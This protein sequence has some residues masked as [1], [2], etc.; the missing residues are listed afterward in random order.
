MILELIMK[1]KALDNNVNIIDRAKSKIE[2]DQHVVHEQLLK[3]GCS[4]MDAVKITKLAMELTRTRYDNLPETIHEIYQNLNICMAH[5][6]GQGQQDT[7]QSARD[8]E[9]E[10]ENLEDEDVFFSAVKDFETDYDSPD[11]EGGG[12]RILE[13]RPGQDNQA[14][15]QTDEVQR[16]TIQEV[17]EVL[18]SLKVNQMKRIKIALFKNG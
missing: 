15:S 6:Q 10:A 16:P 4:K 13:E 11:E 2:T 18:N 3:S 9:L 1:G 7:F 8:L 5:T 12:D 14:I 17:L